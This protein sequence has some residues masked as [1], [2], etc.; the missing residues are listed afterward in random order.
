MVVG[1]KAGASTCDAGSAPRGRW[2]A[3]LCRPRRRAR[4]SSRRSPLPAF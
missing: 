3:L 1:A 2:I 4:G